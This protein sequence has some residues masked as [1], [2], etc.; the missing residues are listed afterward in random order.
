MKTKP[1]SEERW[2]A[3]L[4]SP[5]LVARVLELEAVVAM[6]QELFGEER[7]NSWAGFGDFLTPDESK[8]PKTKGK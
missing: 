3:A 2:R 4:M 8:K 6:E 1:V 7:D 5:E